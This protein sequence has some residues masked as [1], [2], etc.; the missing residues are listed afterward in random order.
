MKPSDKIL[1]ISAHGNTPLPNKYFTSHKNLYFLCDVGKKISSEEVSFY[2][3]KILNNTLDLKTLETNNTENLDKEYK[4]LE[5]LKEILD[6][7]ELVNKGKLSNFIKTFTNVLNK[8]EFPLEKGYFEHNLTPDSG[9]LSSQVMFQFS[10]SG[11]TISDVFWGVEKSCPF[12]IAFYKKEIIEQKP[13]SFVGLVLIPS[14]KYKSFSLS[15]LLE[16]T[17]NI[18]IYL[19]IGEK[20]VSLLEATEEQIPKDI[21]YSHQIDNFESIIIGDCR[22]YVFDSDDLF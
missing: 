7:N 9:G 5:E 20:I 15:D 2:L 6:K 3:E 18:T 13:L 12:S 4:S 19:K 10:Q 16:L 22:S 14:E 1:F 11:L 17:K 8:Q 21:I